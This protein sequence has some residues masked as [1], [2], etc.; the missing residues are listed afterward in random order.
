M[1]RLQSRSNARLAHGAKLAACATLAVV[2]APVARLEAAPA[3]PVKLH[4]PNPH[5][6]EYKG[7]PTL[8]IS[9]AEHYGA[10][11]NPDFDTVKYLDTLA[12]ARMNL[13]RLWVG[14]YVED[15]S[16]F[17]I[18]NNTLAPKPERYLSPWARSREPGFAGGDSNKFDL[19]K[20][21]PAFWKRLEAY[22]TEA[23]KRDILVEIVLFCPFY[24]DSMWRVSPINPANNVNGIG[25]G[26]GRLDV[27]N[28]KDAKVTAFMDAYVRKMVTTL[29]RFDNIYF[30]L[31]NEPYANKSI[32]PEFQAHVADLI[33][34]TEKRLPKKHLIAQNY[35]NGSQKIEKPHPAVS[36]LNFHYA[37]P[38]TAVAE[39]YHHGKVIADDE[40]GFRGQRDLPYRIE[41]WNFMLAGGGIYNNL[42]YSFT[43]GHEDGTWTDFPQKQPGGGGP[44]LRRQLGILRTLLEAMPF[45]RMAPA[46][47]ALAGTKL[48]EGLRAQVLAAPGKH[49]A[50]YLSTIIDKKTDQAALE[51]V[52]RQQDIVVD[53]P[54]GNYR[55]EWLD[56]RTGEIARRESLVHKGGRQTL[57]APTFSTDVA[58]RIVEKAAVAGA[59]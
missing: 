41:A 8:V 31:V 50:I 10:V 5:Y 47:D 9:S 32:S 58:L 13:T 24:A 49:Y 16:A 59:P 54:A 55:V 19:T 4:G 25:A 27:Y 51:K 3:G 6:L 29:N 57:S 37:A 52:T 43:V 44:T 21:D 38:P 2:T 1:P 18:S 48:G 20:W 11:L 7:K 17:H 30:E 28:M 23:Q 40:T 46:G 53:L 14:F 22:L 15:D 36:I 35:S 33:V 34:A 56:P 39:N 26:L 42:D 12:A 45:T